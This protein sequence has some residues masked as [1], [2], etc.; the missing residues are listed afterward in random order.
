[1]SS[2]QAV[3]KALDESVNGPQGPWSSSR[4]RSLVLPNVI[5]AGLGP[6][7]QRAEAI[8]N[9]S[10]AGFI[11]EFQDL[12]ERSSWYENEDKIIDVSTVHKRGGALAIVRYHSTAATTPGG[13]PVE[14]GDSMATLMWDGAR[15]WVV[16]DTF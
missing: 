11:K 1:V 5:L 7:E 16:A 3:V 14:D 2:P 12:H 9:V 10:L 13:T 15:W 8:S 4:L 6:N